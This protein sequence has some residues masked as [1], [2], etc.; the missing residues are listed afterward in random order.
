MLNSYYQHVSRYNNSLITRFYGVHC[1][2]PLNGQKVRDIYYY[3]LLLKMFSAVM[4]S[5]NFRLQ[6]RFIVMGNLFCSEY[7]IHR[8]FDLKGSSYGRTADKFDDEIDETTTLKDLDLNFVFRLQRSW[9][10]D[11]HE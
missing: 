1:V 9:Y 3:N 8:R 5:D 6:V 7:R 10:N 4:V 11:L 2:K